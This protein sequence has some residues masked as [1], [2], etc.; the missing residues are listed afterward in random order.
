MS[1]NESQKSE[2]YPIELP[3][4]NN[5]LEHSPIVDVVENENFPFDVNS[6][7]HSGV[8]IESFDDISEVVATETEADTAAQTIRGL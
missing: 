1:K 7:H 4:R 3:S 5:G 6:R 2:K 8:Q